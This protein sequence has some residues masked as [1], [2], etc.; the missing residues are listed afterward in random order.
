MYMRTHTRTHL[1]APDGRGQ[2]GE[3]EEGERGGGG[4]EAAGHGW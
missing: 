2:A 4:R 1:L 3:E